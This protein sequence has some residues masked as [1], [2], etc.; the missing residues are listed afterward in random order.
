MENGN[1]KSKLLWGLAIGAA[2]GFVLGYLLSGKKFNEIGKDIN[3]VADNLKEKI[4]DT[5]DKSKEVIEN[6]N[7]KV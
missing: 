5:L 4:N 6:I 2:A 3:N 1:N 7:S